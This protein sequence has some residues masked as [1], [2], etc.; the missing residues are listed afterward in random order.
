MNE[1]LA[2]VRDGAVTVAEACR[3]TGYSRGFIYAAMQRGD[4]PYVKIGGGRRIPRR[5]LELWLA[6]HLMVGNRRVLDDESA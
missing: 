1:A 4:L 3:I 2:L 5:A 6:K